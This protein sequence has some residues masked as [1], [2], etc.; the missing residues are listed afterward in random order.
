MWKG[1]HC[2]LLPQ[3][4]AFFALRTDSWREKEK[5][6]GWLSPGYRNRRLP[7]APSP[8][9]ANGV[10]NTHTRTPLCVTSCFTFLLYTLHASLVC[11]F[12][13]AAATGP[14][15]PGC[16]KTGAATFTHMYIQKRSW[17]TRFTESV[18]IWLFLYYLMRSKTAIRS[19]SFKFKV[20][21]R[22]QGQ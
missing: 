8:G 14:C 1:R 20:F 18:L 9:A 4:S 6:G 17:P 15:A 12:M 22:M 7:P 11:C 13:G 19:T 2:G 21:M 5:E 3:R 10:S 16:W